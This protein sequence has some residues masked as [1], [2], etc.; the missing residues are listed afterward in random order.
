[1]KY[2]EYAASIEYDEDSRTFFAVLLGAFGC[3]KFKGNSPD[4]VEERFREFIDS[5]LQEC[6]KQR[7]NPEKQFSGKLVLRMPPKMHADLALKARKS[8]ISLNQ[9]MTKELEKAVEQAE[10]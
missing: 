3:L 7:K 6:K 5:Y 10:R 2:K 9:L 1:M 8:G 4:E